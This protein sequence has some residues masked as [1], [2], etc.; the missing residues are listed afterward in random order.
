M[1]PFSCMARLPSLFRT[2][3]L[4][5]LTIAASKEY[6]TFSPYKPK[7]EKREKMRVAFHSAHPNGHWSDHIQSGRG[8][9]VLSFDTTSEFLH[10]LIPVILDISTTN[11]SGKKPSLCSPSK[12][13]WKP[14]QYC[15]V[16]K[17]PHVV[18]W[19]QHHTCHTHLMVAI[20]NLDATCTSHT[21]C[22]HMPARTICLASFVNWQK[23]GCPPTQELLYVHWPDALTVPI[24]LFSY[25]LLHSL[26]A[27]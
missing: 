26:L 25:L 20:A 7:S 24:T 8:S 10:F 22:T 15:K 27:Q 2:L 23:L 9:K 3:P 19:R 18:W 4:S 5:P 12:I 16:L 21:A 6:C 11:S 13:L 17:Q 14:N 1:S